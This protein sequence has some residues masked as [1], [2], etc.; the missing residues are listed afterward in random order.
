[1]GKGDWQRPVD[2]RFKKQFEK[3][4]QKLFG[5]KCRLPHKHDEECKKENQNGKTKKKNKTNA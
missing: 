3:N 5:N 1:M 4:K 2:A